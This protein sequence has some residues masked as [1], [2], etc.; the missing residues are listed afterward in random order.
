MDK[1]TAFTLS[2]NNPARVPRGRAG[3]LSSGGERGRV[4]EGRQA[5][6]GA[7]QDSG[8]RG[9]AGRLLFLALP[10]ARLSL[11]FL[12]QL[13]DLARGKFHH[14]SLVFSRQWLL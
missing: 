6:P 5:G 14:E 2:R 9:G 1:P 7:P 8:R 3:G 13:F 10:R 11:S 12:L 4:G